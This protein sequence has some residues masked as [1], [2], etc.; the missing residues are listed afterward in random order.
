MVLCI[1]DTRVNLCS[2][3]LTT[4][5]INC[6]L[7][8]YLQLCTISSSEGREQVASRGP[9][10]IIIIIC[11]LVPSKLKT[12]QRNQWEHVKLYKQHILPGNN[13]S[14]FSKISTYYSKMK[15]NNFDQ[16][17]LGQIQINIGNL[18]VLMCCLQTVKGIIVCAA[19]AFRP[20]TRAVFVH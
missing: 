17:S 5:L 3:C 18:L 14:I 13:R 15:R 20:Q 2:I 16:D 4:Y 12:D 7:I 10:A 6:L 9:L 1:Y 19:D 11:P 8:V